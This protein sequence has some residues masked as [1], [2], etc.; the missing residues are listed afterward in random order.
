LFYPAS[1]SF[2]PKQNTTQDAI[3]FSAQLQ[4]FLQHIFFISH[5]AYIVSEH[6]YYKLT[7]YM[8]LIVV[9]AL[10]STRL[11]ELKL[12]VQKIPCTTIGRYSFSC[13]SY[14]TTTPLSSLSYN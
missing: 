13:H 10:K 6:L 1:I 11:V 12:W 3:I 7:S 5:H 8:P 4:G 2:R 9:S 14:T